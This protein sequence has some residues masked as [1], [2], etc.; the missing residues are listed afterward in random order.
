MLR[1]SGT[2]FHWLAFVVRFFGI[3]IK[4]GVRGYEWG[5]PLFSL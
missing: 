4:V 2:T 3:G 1:L 5:L